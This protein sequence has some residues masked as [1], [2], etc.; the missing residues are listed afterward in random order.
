MKS[1]ELMCPKKNMGKYIC[2]IHLSMYETSCFRNST[3]R[4]DIYKSHV[5][6]SHASLKE[7]TWLHW[8]SSI[9]YHVAPVDFT[10]STTPA[11][12]GTKY[13]TQIWRLRN[14]TANGKV[15]FMCPV[16]AM[17]MKTTCLEAETGL[18]VFTVFLIFQSR[19]KHDFSRSYQANNIQ[20]LSLAKNMVYMSTLP[21]HFDTRHSFVCV[22]MVSRIKTSVEF[23]TAREP[24]LLRTQE[25]ERK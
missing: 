15:G 23:V 24:K 21:N 11:L 9:G 22:A 18:A 13:D 8:S 12:S 19:V 7:N 4:N 3:Y 5:T 1:S 17:L 16:A 20:R 25:R 10:T 2:L 14:S 6:P